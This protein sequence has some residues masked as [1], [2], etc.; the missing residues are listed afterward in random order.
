MQ[1]INSRVDT[2]HPC[3]TDR[4]MAIYSDNHP[5]FFTVTFVSLYNNF[6]QLIYFT[7]IFNL[8]NVSLVY[9]NSRLAVLKIAYSYRLR[10]NNLLNIVIGNFMYYLF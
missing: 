8:F 3:F 7:F 10:L 9:N 6:I 5:L 4:V 2:G 1:I